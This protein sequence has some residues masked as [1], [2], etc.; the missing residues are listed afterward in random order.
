[1]ALVQSGLPTSSYVF[2]GFPPRKSGQ[3]RRFLAMEVNLP[4]TIVLYESPYRIAALLKDALEELGNRKAAVCIELTKMF[5]SVERG[6]L[7]DLARTFSDVQVKGE[8]TVVIAGNNPKFIGPEETNG[9]HAG[10]SGN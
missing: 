2:K 1:V 3:R 4:H 5:E 6:Y 9:E 7:A 8:T 10:A